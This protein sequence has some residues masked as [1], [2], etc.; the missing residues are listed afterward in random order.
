MND[1]NKGKYRKWYSDEYRI[2]KEVLAHEHGKLEWSKNDYEAFRFT[3]EHLVLIFYPHKTSA[4]NYH[5]R[6]RDQHSK[7]RI[8]AFQLM[9]RLDRAAGYNC[10]MTMKKLE[11]R[12]YE[13]YKTRTGGDRPES[14]H[15][16][17]DMQAMQ[18]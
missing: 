15:D 8:H 11:Q 7:N 6:V 18:P 4:G 9:R 14:I 16:Q 10:T 12:R 1:P 2:A 3:S 13:L 5:L 17:T